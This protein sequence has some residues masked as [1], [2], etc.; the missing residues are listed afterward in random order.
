MSLPTRILQT[1]VSFLLPCFAQ[2]LYSNPSFFSEAIGNSENRLKLPL[3]GDNGRVYVCSGRNFFAFESNGSIAWSVALNHT[4][5]LKIAPVNGGSRKIYVVA[6]DR[7]LKINPLRIGGSQSAVQVFFGAKQTGE[8]SWGEIVGIA[9]SIFSSRVLITI[10]RRG[11]FAYKLHG[12]L[13]WSA[14]PVK[15]QH[16]FRQGCSKNLEDCYFSSAPVVDHCEARAYVLNN[17]GELYAVSTSSPHFLWITDLSTFGNIS[18]ITAGNNGLVYVTV[19]DKA[20]I[21]ALDASR[22]EILWQGSIGP[23]STADYT[24]IIDSNGWVS[25]GSLD[26]FVYSFSL[27]GVLKKFSTV[28]DQDSV[29]QASPIL[30]CSG[31]AIYVSQTLMDGKVSQTI[32]SYTYISAMKPRS[33]TFI[34]LVPAT[35]NLLLS[36]KYPGLFSSK[37]VDSDLKHFICDEKVILAFFAASK[38]NNPFQCISTR[39]KFAYS[40]SQIRP[41]TTDIYTSNERAIVLFLWFESALL[42]VLAALVRFCCIFWKKK[43]LQS[44][45]LG[46][47]LEKR[48]S[49][50]LQKKAYDRTISELEQKAAKEAVRH[51][52][53][54]QLGDLMKEREGIERKLSTTY[55]FGRDETT[56]MRGSKSLL[57]LSD[58]TT[59]SYSFQDGNKESITLFHTGSG[60]SSKDSE[61]ELAETW[62]CN[63]DD[64]EICEDEEYEASPSSSSSSSHGVT[65]A[66]LDEKG[67]GVSHQS[68]LKRRMR[69]LSS[70]S[71]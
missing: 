32:G 68:V 2:I 5:S 48:R 43:K 56:I 34:M 46:G 11:L 10:K 62:I 22:G 31:Y 33:V 38:T 30:D 60:A 23:L 42:L 14:G 36:E 16:G 35:G 7:V 40:C 49:L 67:E 3:V 39:Q 54:E 64:D 18:A 27:T 21:L 44:R 70:S 58:R 52:M 47:F 55:S 63:D 50:R 45:Q 61:S 17:G 15:N 19:P 69:F 29:I 26:G 66:T 25:V 53:I 24:P 20:L 1:L 41:M 71:S 65:E 13:A 6:E 37:L 28:G 9:V 51:E 59:R 57:P 8:E 4:C 12:K